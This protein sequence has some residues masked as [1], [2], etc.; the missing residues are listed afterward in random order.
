[1]QW[2]Q[3]T[4]LNSWVW[5]VLNISYVEVGEVYVHKV[6]QTLSIF[7]FYRWNDFWNLAV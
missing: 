1:M 7:C 6:D 3:N 4:H 5:E 2:S